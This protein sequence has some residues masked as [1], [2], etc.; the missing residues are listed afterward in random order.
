MGSDTRSITA[1]EGFSIHVPAV[2]AKREVTPQSIF[3]EWNIE[4]QT[5]FD[6]YTGVIPALFL[7]TLNIVQKYGC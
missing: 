2:A 7:V 3:S 6:L 1:G 5:R 4:D